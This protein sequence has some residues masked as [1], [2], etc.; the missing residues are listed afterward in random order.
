VSD[1]HYDSNY[2]SEGDASH[3]CHYGNGSGAEVGEFGNYL[4]DAPWTLIT[5][6]MDAMY[7]IKANPDFIIWTG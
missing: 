4:C 2:T 3:M 7:K 6:A 1:F 5:S